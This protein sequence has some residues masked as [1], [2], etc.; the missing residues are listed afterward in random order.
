M[1]LTVYIKYTLQQEILMNNYKVV[2]LQT[3]TTNYI[4][5]LYVNL[6]KFQLI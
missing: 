2:H 4:N 3:Y 6:R 5:L 1:N